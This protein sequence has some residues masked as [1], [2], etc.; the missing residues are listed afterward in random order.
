[1]KTLDDWNDREPIYRQLRDRLEAM[2]IAGAIREGDSLPSVRR[3]AAEERLNPL[4]VSRA[5]QMLAANGLVEPQRGR[6]MFVTAGGRR[7]ALE[8]ARRRFLD[9]E[10]PRVRRRIDQ[11]GLDARHLVEPPGAGNDRQEH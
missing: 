2:I 3:I 11:L 9:E 4:T 8:H 7:R 1:M 5:F 6:G 10:W